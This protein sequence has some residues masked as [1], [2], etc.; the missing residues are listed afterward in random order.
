MEACA[1]LSPMLFNDLYLL[2]RVPGVSTLSLGAAEPGNFDEHLK[3]LYE[4]PRRHPSSCPLS[5]PPPPPC[6][7]ARPSTAVSVPLCITARL[8]QCLP[9]ARL[10]VR[11]GV[12]VLHCRDMMGGNHLKKGSPGG[13][14][15]VAAAEKRLEAM[16]IEALGAD[17]AQH[18]SDSIPHWD[19]C[20]GKINIKVILWLRTLVLSYGMLEYAQDRYRG[21][22]TSGGQSTWYPG[23]RAE[24]ALT[25]RSEIV[26]ACR[27]NQ[28]GEPTARGS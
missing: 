22:A 21:L 15:L 4:P 18:W 13:E 17:Y 26:E 6:R 12:C 11:L 7:L 2:T 19:A 16:K 10:D 27:G 25:L 23:G 5:S 24:E 20:P 28:W 8:T 9:T 1:P 14:Q 3:A